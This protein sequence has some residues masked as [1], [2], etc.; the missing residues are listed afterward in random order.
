MMA[1]GPLRGR[2]LGRYWGS[3]AQWTASSV[4]KKSIG[5][6]QIMDCFVGLVN[7]LFASCGGWEYTFYVKKRR[8]KIELRSWVCHNCEK[9]KRTT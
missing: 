4:N 5:S 6:I 8:R 7:T 1:S 3:S 9:G 2:L